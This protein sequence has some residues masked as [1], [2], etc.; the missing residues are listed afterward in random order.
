MQFISKYEGPW[1]DLEQTVDINTGEWRVQRPVGKPGKCRKC[2]YC[3]IFCP[4]GCIEE[5][6][7]AFR[8]NLDYC[9][10]CGICAR[11]CPANAI[12]LIRE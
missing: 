4:T 12:M 6:P 8:A 11:M 5:T 7:I 3:F 2:G 1:A 9:K 10:G